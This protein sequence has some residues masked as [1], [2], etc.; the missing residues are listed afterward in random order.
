ME[1]LFTVDLM[2]AWK[3]KQIH[4]STLLPPSLPVLWF[5]SCRQVSS[6][7]C[8]TLKKWSLTGRERTTTAT[9]CFSPRFTST[10][11]KEWDVLCFV[12]PFWTYHI[13]LYVYIFRTP[14]DLTYNF[15]ITLTGSD[16]FFF[17]A[18]SSSSTAFFAAHWN[19]KDSTDFILSHINQTHLEMALEL[20]ARSE[21]TWHSDAL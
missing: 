13:C 18:F 15:H 21:G 5:C 4:F 20:R 2:D 19:N 14:C 3:W 12:C 11:L 16:N 6:A 1:S 9:S 8:P 7:T 17:T 10:Q